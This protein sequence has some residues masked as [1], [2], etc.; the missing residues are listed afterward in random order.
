MTN[1]PYHS[2]LA[3]GRLQDAPPLT[4]PFTHMGSTVLCWDIN[5]EPI[6]DAYHRC[7]VIYADPPWSGGI[8]VFDQRAGVVSPDYDEHARRIGRII[9]DLGKPTVLLIGATLSARLPP[10]DFSMSVML[11]GTRAQA[12]F[13][14]GAYALGDVSTD[15]IRFLAKTYNCVGDFFCGYGTTGRLFAEAGKSFVM[16]DYN[17]QCCGFVAREMTGWWA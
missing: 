11:N 13:W 10:A 12:S 8:S 16:S 7:D 17:A 2:A 14:N 5:R 15:L 6:P 3:Q 4:A 1:A 9:T